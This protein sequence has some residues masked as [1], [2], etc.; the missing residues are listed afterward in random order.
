MVEITPERFL[1]VIQRGIRP[2]ELELTIL[3][4]LE[5]LP[6]DDHYERS[7]LERLRKL[8]R[9]LRHESRI[10]QFEILMISINDIDSGE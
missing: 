6:F 3:D 9:S 8:I 4:L 1:L 7:L 5:M 2:E 10:Q